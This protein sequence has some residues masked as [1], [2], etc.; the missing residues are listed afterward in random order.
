MALPAVVDRY[1]ELETRCI[2]LDAVAGFADDGLDAIDRHDR[3]DAETIALADMDEIIK[4]RRRQFADRAKEAVVAR[5]NRE[6]AEIILQRL[7]VPRLDETHR[8]GFA[9]T[10]LQGVRMLPEIIKT[11]RGHRRLPLISSFL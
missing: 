8:H 2:G 3:D 7:G 11:K 6:P 10:K 1:A 5:A 4:F 9:G